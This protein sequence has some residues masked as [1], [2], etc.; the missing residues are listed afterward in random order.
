MFSLKRGSKGF[1]LI[2]LLVVIAII[3]ILA[4][5][6]FPV[7]ARARRAA[8]RTSCLN[9]LKNIVTA[10]VMYGNDWE[11]RFPLASGPGPEFEKKIANWPGNSGVAA[12]GNLRNVDGNYAGAGERRWFQ[13]LI[14]P[15][16]KN[17]KIFMCPSVGQMGTWRVTGGTV[18]YKFNRHGGAIPTEPT[19]LRVPASYSG[20]PL[21]ASADVDPATSYW[22]N[23]I[24][25]RQTAYA[26]ASYS[27]MALIVA[28]QPE[29]ICDKVADASIV[30]DTPCG[31]NDGSGEAALAHEDSINVGYADGHARSFR[32]TL[33]KVAPWINDH[34]GRIK[35]WEGWF[36]E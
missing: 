5:I 4:A 31:F 19:N 11:D 36:P 9:N 15:Y 20:S 13:N 14:V 6:L 12:N 16:A 27:T 25:D 32:V 10:C 22:F 7:F 24:A 18:T 8:Q 26:G 35:G 23:S 2:E 30:W 33:P 3:A 17:T 29:G 1:T 34:Y 28:G 21:P